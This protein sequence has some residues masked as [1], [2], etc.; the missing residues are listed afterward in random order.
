MNFV[1]ENYIPNSFLKH[2]SNI[3]ADTN[4]GLSGREIINFF[5][6]YAVQFNVDIKY[7][8]YPFEKTMIA[9]R[10]AFY[11]NLLCFSSE[12]QYEIIKD[13]ASY[14]TLNNYE[15]AKEVKTQLVNR[16]GHLAMNRTDNAELIEKTDHWLQEYPEALHYY[17]TGLTKY[18][19]NVE[20]RSAADDMRVALEILLK[21]ILNNKKSLEKQKS[22]LGAFLKE[23]NI[24]REIRNKF[25]STLNFY[26]DFQNSHV[27][28]TDDVEI[29][30]LEVE[31]VVELTSI[32]IKFIVKTAKNDIS[33]SF[34]GF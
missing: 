12:E 8:N 27:K 14:L 17:Q 10:D 11:E 20:Y 3:L 34:K 26:T 16:Y 33:G 7:S 5:V 24:S 2:A 28:H 19:N 6:D 21:E 4:H 31:F 18:K 22:E 23:K 29:N 32:I 25:V 30:K 13:I 9:K 1:D 15:K